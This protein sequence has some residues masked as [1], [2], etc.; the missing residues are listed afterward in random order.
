MIRIDELEHVIVIGDRLLIQP[1]TDAGQTKSGLFLPP[2][3]QEHEAV[4]S[5]YVVKIGPGYALP[6]Q[7][8]LEP[9]QK[10]EEAVQY[11][12]LQAKVGDVAVFM[13]KHAVEI[14]LIDRHGDEKK[15][16]VVPQSAVLL[17]YRDE[18]LLED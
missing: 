5:G 11:V 8:S 1:R 6:K 10:H 12:P 9:W 2:S 3:V 17:L 4:S 13:Q 16:L 7:E 15:F 18:G 14:R